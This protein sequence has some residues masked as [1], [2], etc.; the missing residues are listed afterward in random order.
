[1]AWFLL[2]LAGLFE[3][4]FTTSMKASEG[5]S[6]PLPTVAFLFCAIASFVFLALAVRTLP[7]GSA[8]AVWTG[9][10]AAGTIL[11]GIL[12]YGEDRSPLRLFFL[13]LIIV[14]VVGVRFTTKEEPTASIEPSSQ[15]GTS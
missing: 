9:L 14:A 12:I 8:Y 4:G 3:V 5:F 15:S 10:G 11:V 13:A 7:I 2:L 1:M 6:R